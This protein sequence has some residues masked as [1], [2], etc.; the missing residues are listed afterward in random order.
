MCASSDMKRRTRVA[1]SSTRATLAAVLAAVLLAV[2]SAVD[3]PPIEYDAPTSPVLSEGDTVATYECSESPTGAG[4][5]F[6]LDAGSLEAVNLAGSNYNGALYSW[7]ASVPPRLYTTTNHQ[8]FNQGHTSTV[9][10]AAVPGSYMQWAYESTEL[11]RV[12]V[13][14]STNKVIDNTKIGWGMYFKLGGVDA[15]EYADDAAGTDYTETVDIGVGHPSYVKVGHNFHPWTE[16]TPVQYRL[17]FIDDNNGGV[18][19]EYQVHDGTSWA[20][21]HTS[22]TSQPLNTPLYLNVATYYW[23]ISYFSSMVMVGAL[24]GTG[25]GSF[26]L[27]GTNPLYLDT[28]TTPDSWRARTQAEGPSTERAG[29][30]GSSYA[31]FTEQTTHPTSCGSAVYAWSV[32][33]VDKTVDASGSSPAS[34]DCVVL[35]LRRCYTSNDGYMG[36]PRLSHGGDGG[37]APDAVMPLN[38]QLQLP[39]TTVGVGTVKFYV[40]EHN[41]R[42]L[43]INHWDGNAWVSGSQKLQCYGLSKTDGGPVVT[44]GTNNWEELYGPELNIFLADQTTAGEAIFHV[45]TFYAGGIYVG[46]WNNDLSLGYVYLNEQVTTYTTTDPPA[47]AANLALALS[48]L[49]VDETGLEVHATL[50]LSYPSSLDASDT[51]F[52]PTLTLHG[53]DADYKNDVSVSEGCTKDANGNIVFSTVTDA[54]AG[55]STCKVTGTGDAIAEG[56]EALQWQLLSSPNGVAWSEAGESFQWVAGDGGVIQTLSVNV[57]CAPPTGAPTGDTTVGAGGLSSFTWYTHDDATGNS[58]VSNYACDTGYYVREEGV[59]LNRWLGSTT[60]TCDVSTKRYT[61][62]TQYNDVNDIAAPVLTC[63]QP[64]LPAQANGGCAFDV[65]VPTNKVALCTC[66]ANF[67]T[68][69]CAGVAACSP[70]LNLLL[71]GVAWGTLPDWSTFSGQAGRHTMGGQQSLWFEVGTSHATEYWAHFAKLQGDATDYFGTV[72]GSSAFKITNKLTQGGVDKIPDAEFT[73]DKC[74][75]LQQTAGTW[76]GPTLG[77]TPITD[78]YTQTNPYTAANMIGDTYYLE[79]VDYPAGKRFRI[80]GVGSLTYETVMTTTYPTTWG[81]QTWRGNWDNYARSS[82]LVMEEVAADGSRFSPPVYATAPD[83]SG[84]VGH[85]VTDAA[86]MVNCFGTS[87]GEASWKSDT[88]LAFGAN[89]KELYD[90]MDGTAQAS[91]AC[92]PTAQLTLT[93]LSI[94]ENDA[95]ATLTFHFVDVGVTSLVVVHTTTGHIEDFDVSGDGCEKNAGTG[96]ITATFLSNAV[97]GSHVCTITAKADATLE[98]PEDFTWTLTLP[99]GWAVRAGGT[100]VV[101]LTVNNQV[102]NCVNDATCGASELYQNWVGSAADAPVSI[103][104]GTFV[105][106]MTI[107]GSSHFRGGDCVQELQVVDGTPVGTSYWTSLNSGAKVRLSLVLGEPSGGVSTITSGRAHLCTGAAFQNGDASTDATMNACLSDA[108]DDEVWEG[109]VTGTITAAGYATGTIALDSTTGRRARAN[110]RCVDWSVGDT[111]TVSFR[112]TITNGGEMQFAT[113]GDWKTTYYLGANTV[114]ANSGWE[115][116]A[117]IRWQRARNYLTHWDATAASTSVVPTVANL[118]LDAASMPCAMTWAAGG[119]A[120]DV[121]DL[122]LTSTYANRGSCA[123]YTSVN[124]VGVTVTLPDDGDI[125]WTDAA[126]TPPTYG[127]PAGSSTWTIT[128]TTSVTMQCAVGYRITE[129]G[130]VQSIGCGAAGQDPCAKTYTCNENTGTYSNYAD[131]LTLT[132]PVLACVQP[133]APT[134]QSGSCAFTGNELITTVCTCGNSYVQQDCSNNPACAATL[135]LQDDGVSWGATANGGV[136]QPPICHGCGVSPLD[137]SI[138]SYG[139]RS[140]ASG[141]QGDV[142]TYTCD[143]CY[144]ADTCACGD[145]HNAGTDKCTIGSSYVLNALAGIGGASCTAP[146]PVYDVGTH[147]YNPDQKSVFITY[148]QSCTDLDTRTACSCRHTLTGSATI[149]CQLVDNIYAWSDVAS[150]TCAPAAYMDLVPTS[151]T[152]TEIN[153]ALSAYYPTDYTGGAVD[154][155]FSHAAGGTGSAADIVLVGGAGCAYN[156][157]TG[158]VTL[159]VS[160]F[161]SGTAACTIRAIGE[162]LLEPAETINYALGNDASMV[163]LDMG[164]GYVASV[165][166]TLTINNQVRSRKNSI[167]L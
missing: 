108:G 112:G 32:V 92:T 110:Y 163:T 54:S 86:E 66:A 89:Y 40:K 68:E 60:Y 31:W 55:P 53:G 150:P 161:S 139:T 13:G 105:S 83:Y 151:I 93:P 158:T 131:G 123:A 19:A 20:T 69:N 100:D 56:V 65:G 115:A 137:A 128:G 34:E 147:T 148:Q 152:E 140:A 111:V 103:P 94:T 117:P 107:D 3:P 76:N 1:G 142:I 43:T 126:C 16:G 18:K 124:D 37:E 159:S 24:Y 91:P 9:S 143:A 125:D 133:V 113:G 42:E 156:S 122:E 121:S 44:K 5:T 90:R 75:L 146:A 49:T 157:G 109:D 51:P 12:I 35:G 71:A 29:V 118:V 36:M 104:I 64:A 21:M 82:C 62:Y 8:T 84:I 145:A 144:V 30:D 164:D 2:T 70:T 4:T 77:L 135:H 67:N 11:T 48:P 167:Y 120:S 127:A 153:A 79:T 78:R 88:C 47:C 130:V 119:T 154:F 46:S 38:T 149:T 26:T 81:D 25:Q 85:S 162:G 15:S 129:A 28:S 155:T 14:A 74:L 95:S 96:D 39:V 63:D 160:D 98:P 138:T 33:K 165:T 61:E 6:T 52:T 134:V 166:E 23:Q 101:T 132:E 22:V 27:L 45:G 7:D 97:S 141:L 73:T 10:V 50:L 87:G 116:S 80:S 41:V 72:A 136:L 59:P 99:T 106:T 17:Y 57:N 58:G 102:Y 114:E